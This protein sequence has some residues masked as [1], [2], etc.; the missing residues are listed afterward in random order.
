MYRHKLSC[1]LTRFAPNACLLTVALLMI[2]NC[3]SEK[4]A[5][6]P[7]PD[8]PI[9][10]RVENDSTTVIDVIQAK[11]CGANAKA[12]KPQM[13]SIK[14]R[15]RIMLQIYQQCVDL[16]ALDA[17]GNVMDELVGLR[18]NSNITWKIK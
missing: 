8:H 11:P 16:V 7:P 3:S 17:F 10:L 5:L 6:I 18:L 14:P 13:T 2:N 9:Q 15:E 12:Y 1:P 4:P